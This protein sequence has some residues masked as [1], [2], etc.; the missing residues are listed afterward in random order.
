[1]NDVNEEDLLRHL[2][3]SALPPTGAVMPSRDLWPDV[4]R[5]SRRRT[6]WTSLDSSLAAIIVLALLLFPKWFW[7]LAY[8]L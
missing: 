2:L 3:Q 1:M 7:F 4:A 8:H 5:R 6:R